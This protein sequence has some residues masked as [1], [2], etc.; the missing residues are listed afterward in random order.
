MMGSTK[1]VRMWIDGKCFNIKRYKSKKPSTSKNAFEE[2]PCTSTVCDHNFI[3]NPAQDGRLATTFR[4]PSIY[5]IQLNS[6]PYFSLKK[7]ELETNTEISMP[8]NG[9]DGY[10]IVTG[11]NEIDI[12][13][14]REGIQSVVSEIR[15]RQKVTHFTSIPVHSEEVQ[16]SFQQF[17]VTL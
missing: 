13:N 4:L 17:K 2:T 1:P 12:V 5:Y 15:E 10:I 3:I 8:K 7:L 6:S 14:A 9:N 11:N 16:R